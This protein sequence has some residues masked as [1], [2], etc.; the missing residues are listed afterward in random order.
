MARISKKE[1]YPIDL[2]VTMDDFLIGTDSV[3]DSTKSYPIENLAA[4]FLENAI[5]TIANIDQN[6]QFKFIYHSFNIGGI[7]QDI[8]T[9]EL[10]EAA[11]LQGIDSF[12]LTNNLTVL[13][14]ELIVFNFM[15]TERDTMFAHERKYLAPNTI[16]KGT[17]A[18]LSGTISADE[19]EVVYVENNIRKASPE[20]IAQNIGNVIYEL[21][22]L[23]G[24]SYLNYINNVYNPNFPNGYD[25]TDNSKVYYFK[26]VDDGTTF[27]YFFNEPISL[28]G[29]VVYGYSG[30]YPFGT[31]D[32]VLYYNSNVSQQIPFR[33]TKTS[34]LT[35]DGDDGVNA[36][37]SE[38]DLAFFTANLPQQFVKNEVPSGIIDGVNATY[39]AAIAFLPETVEVFLNGLKLKVIT[40]YNTSGNDTIQLVFSPLTGE[41]LT[42]NYI[43][44]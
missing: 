7:S 34:E 10:R 38:A 12:L 37:A 27:M 23:T 25:L 3:D 19:L 44:L 1:I 5:E 4:L 13:E 20:D 31:N 18:P 28:N 35:N 33:V 15:I 17:Y 26:W 8:S 36:F 41:I 42:I 40:D 14:T 21:G 2:Q 11:I 22:D 24:L 30:N 32:L 9:I 43:K 6:N 29:Y 39:I 16:T